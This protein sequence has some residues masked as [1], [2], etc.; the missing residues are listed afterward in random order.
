MSSFGTT[1]IA[2]GGRNVKVSADGTPLRP[3]AGI[4]LDWS[5]FTAAVADTTLEDGTV[6]KTGD[7]Y[8]RYGT[9]LTKITQ[10]E[11]QT[12]DLSGGNDPTAGTWTITAL[13]QTTGALAWDASAATVQAA[14]QALSNI[15]FGGVTVTKVGFVYTLTFAGNLGNI[16][17]VTVDSASLTGATLVSIATS[18]QGVVGGEKYGAYA[19]GAT[20]GR[21]TLTRGECYILNK[22]VL[23]SYEESDHPDVIYGGIVYK[24]RITDI[25]T[26]PSWAN[27]LTAFPQIQAAGN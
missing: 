12:I 5:V 13:G 15:G 1:S 23:Q 16:A 24:S 22:T 4:T 2:T 19:S 20:D 6:V 14:L 11:I 25:A 8:A 26:N 27:I 7:K 10:V 3:M 21:Q 9:I 18:T 17:A